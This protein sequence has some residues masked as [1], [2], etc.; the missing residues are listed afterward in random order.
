MGWCIIAPVNDFRYRAPRLVNR[1]EARGARLEKLGDSKYSQVMKPLRVPRPVV[2][3]LIIGFDSEWNPADGRLISVQ[4]AALIGGVLVSSVIYVD[5]LTSQSLFSHVLSFLENNNL[6]TGKRPKRVY[7]ISHFAQS[8]I[9]KIQNYLHE[10]KLRVYNKAMSAEST[11]SGDDFEDELHQKGWAKQGATKLKILDLYGYF[12]RGLDRVGVLVQLPKI[13][14]DAS[15][16]NEIRRADPDLFETYAKRDAEICVKAFTELRSLFLDEFDVDLLKYPTTP[17][18]AGAVFRAKFLDAPIVP[19]RIEARLSHRQ[20]KKTGAWKEFQVVTYVYDG[21]LDLR[22]LALRAY[23]GGRAECYA[24]GF[25]RGYFDY[26][27]VVSLYPSAAMLQPLPNLSTQWL[28]FTSL[29]D[30]VP[31]EGFCAVHFEFPSDAE[32]PCLPVVPAKP[33]KLFFPIKGISFCT[34]AEVRAA[35][36]LGARILEI[37]GFGFAPTRVEQNHPVGNFM[38]RFLGLKETAQRDSLAR[39]MWK[40]VMNALIG[41]FHQSSPEYDENIMLAFMQKTGLESL[42][43]PSFRKYFYR[44]PVVGPC[45]APEWAS[46]I[47]GKARALMAELI[48]RGSLLCS[49]DSGLF[50]KGTNMECGA[51][52]ELRSVGSDFKKEFE[53][54]AIFLARTRLYALIKDGQVVKTARHGTIANERAFADIVIHNLAAR[55]DLGEKAQRTHLATVKDMMQKNKPLGDAETWERSLKW[56]WDGKR[57]LNKPNINLWT[58]FTLT[59]PYN[60]I[61]DF[62]QD[63]KPKARLGRPKALSPRQRV[64]A[65]KLHRQGWSLRK[66]ARYLNVGAATVKRSID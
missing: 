64:T 56:D 21:S 42:S 15:R 2:D 31:L 53:S 51:L 19:Y 32:Y 30:A 20:N 11:F 1:L 66:I 45:W 29:K 52:T 37:R 63:Y 38:R 16:I 34:L 22:H 27:D 57:I 36:K 35:V 26:Y 8:E 59:T 62:P 10:W 46:L 12:S 9:S 58:Q 6:T 14:L 65:Q 39:E 3:P 18:L 4:F 61:P 60:E 7:L 25:T 43:D 48:A 17:S 28:P 54:D 23:W 24:R 47:L 49:T 13:S 40:L 50:V 44:T 41:K 55:R 5:V 33:E